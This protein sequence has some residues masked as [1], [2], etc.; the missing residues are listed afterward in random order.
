MAVR[1][2]GCPGKAVAH[3]V[4]HHGQHRATAL[5]EGGGQ[6][7]LHAAEKAEHHGIEGLRRRIG[8]HIGAQGR[9]IR[10]APGVQ[11]L[12]QHRQGGSVAFR[13]RDMGRMG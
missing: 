10:N 12:P 2:S 1:R 9:H 5:A 6:Y 11:L 8:Q 7:L 13:R 3:V 4:T